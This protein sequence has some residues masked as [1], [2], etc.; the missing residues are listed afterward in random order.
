MAARGLEACRPGALSRR[1]GARPRTPVAWRRR[2][3][4]RRHGSTVNGAWETWETNAASPPTARGRRRWGCP[5]SNTAAPSSG[6]LREETTSW[7][8][9]PVEKLTADSATADTGGQSGGAVLTRGG[10]RQ[11]RG[12]GLLTVALAVR[13]VGKRGKVSRQPAQASEMAATTHLPGA[14]DNVASD[15]CGRRPGCFV[16]AAVA[17]RRRPS[18]PMRARHAA[19][20]R[21]TGGP[22]SSNFSD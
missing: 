3:I 20:P 22:H 18:Q 21:L 8:R 12:F 2:T 1:H 13:S 7:V 9:R 17:E 19:T 5:T 10:G 15:R 16:P 4:A 6:D 14:S 11:R